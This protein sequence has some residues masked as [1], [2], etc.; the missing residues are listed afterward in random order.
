VALLWEQV[1]Q[2]KLPVEVGKTTDSRAAAFIARHGQNVQV[3]VE[4]MPPD[5][6]R[7]G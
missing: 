3:E 4:A 5:L 6:L 7:D 2:Y 1:E